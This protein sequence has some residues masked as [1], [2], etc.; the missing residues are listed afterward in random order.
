MFL[1][2]RTIY[3]PSSIPGGST[4]QMQVRATSPGLFSYPVNTPADW[5]LPRGVDDQNVDF[6]S[7][8]DFGGHRAQ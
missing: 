6:G 3:A 5:L 8:G 7:A 2:V 1:Q 4:E